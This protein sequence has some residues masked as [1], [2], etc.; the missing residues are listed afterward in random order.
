MGRR[1]KVKTPPLIGI[2]VGGPVPGI[3]FRVDM[4]AQAH[5]VLLPNNPAYCAA[6]YT[7][8]PQLTALSEMVAKFSHCIKREKPCDT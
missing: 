1:K 6:S 5:V 8:Y 4:N 2:T 7:Y 3:R